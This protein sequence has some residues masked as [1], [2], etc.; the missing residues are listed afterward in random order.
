MYPITLQGYV[1]EGGSAHVIGWTL[2]GLVQTFSL[3]KGILFWLGGM[4]FV[5]SLFWDIVR[6]CVTRV[7]FWT[8]HK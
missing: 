7:Y 2:I 3:N 6:G 4:N 8:A 1:M 5:L